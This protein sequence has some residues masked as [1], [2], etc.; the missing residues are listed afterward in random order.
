MAP[1]NNL[2][3]QKL[4]QRTHKLEKKWHSAKLEESSMIWQDRLKV[5]RKAL[6]KDK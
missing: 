6:H 4:K 5:Y 3:T 2:N 1:W